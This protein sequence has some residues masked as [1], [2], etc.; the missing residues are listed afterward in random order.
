M[1]AACGYPGKRHDNNEKYMAISDPNSE[2]A[3][4]I[5]ILRLD[6]TLAAF[7]RGLKFV[8]L[9]IRNK[10]SVAPRLNVSPFDK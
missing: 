1:R 9:L 4:P 5:Q 2:A 6:F 8:L 7:L 3:T 10:Y